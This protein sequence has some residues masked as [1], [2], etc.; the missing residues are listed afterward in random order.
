M[1]IE[2]RKKKRVGMKRERKGKKKEKQEKVNNI[3]VTE[4]HLIR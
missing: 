1:Q 2:A 3:F 4:F